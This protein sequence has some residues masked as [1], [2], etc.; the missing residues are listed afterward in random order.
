MTSAQGDEAISSTQT[1]LHKSSRVEPHVCLSREKKRRVRAKGFDVGKRKR[2]RQIM[3]TRKK[4]L[5]NDEC[6][7]LRQQIRA[8]N[9]EVRTADAAATD[10]L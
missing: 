9:K 3:K 5:Q 6:V 2:G 10:G 1:Q 7:L 8:N 4:S